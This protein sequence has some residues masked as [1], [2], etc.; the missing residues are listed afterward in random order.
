MCIDRAGL[1][2]GDGAT[3]HGIF[4]VAFLSEIPNIRIYSPITNDM[5]KL[6]IKDAVDSGMPCAIRYPNGFESERIKKAFYGADH[7]RSVGARCD[8]GKHAE[9]EAVIVT[10][11]RMAE[12]AIAAQA[13]LKAE[14][15]SVGII[16]LEIIKPYDISVDNVLKLLPDGCK[17]IVFLEEE[18][19]SG[20]MGVN[21]CDKLCS[22]GLFS[23]SDIRIMAVDDSFVTDRA[24][25]Q[26]IYESAG[27]DCSDICKTVK[28]LTI[29]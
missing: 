13:E 20:G 12:Y 27:L 16:L 29:K 21:I 6:C 14:N 24:K 22:K 9:I 28:E 23:M 18:I 4:D 17:K 11:G 3:H 19:R 26:T 1:N 8:V 2:A 5:L 10:H 7:I 15:I 25:H